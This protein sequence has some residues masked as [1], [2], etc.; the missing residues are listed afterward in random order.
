VVLSTAV[1]E[2]ERGT[3]IVAVTGSFEDYF[4]LERTIDLE[5][6]GDSVLSAI[7][8][9]REMASGGYLVGDR[10]IPW[11]RVYDRDGGIVRIL[12]GQ[13]DGP[14]EFRA[15]SGAVETPH[16]I[17]VTD[18][19]RGRVTRFSAIDCAVDTIFRVPGQ[20][21]VI[22][23]TGSE[24]LIHIWGRA[25]GNVLNL[26]NLDL[27]SRVEFKP[28]DS[29]VIKTPYWRS[30]SLVETAI[31]GNT[32]LAVDE[33]LYPIEVYDMDGRRLGEFGTPPP[34]WQ[35][36]PPV[37][38]A[39]FAGP[40]MAERS[41]E[42]LAKFTVMDRIDVYRDSYV[43]VTHARNAPSAT[44]LFGRDHYAIDV[45]D[46]QGRKLLEDIP[47]PGEIVGAGDYLYAVVGSPPDPWKV[48][49]F[50]IKPL[51]VAGG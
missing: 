21:A 5:E 17:Y 47:V 35:P 48:G 37:E 40:D 18:V 44:D 23:F 43:V 33:F 4:S 26:V 8:T 32:I 20:P 42:W 24:L 15:V 46:K 22:D 11:L 50:A 25:S 27:A 51:E 13:G 10:H 3:P 30:F 16:G 7:G 14:G 36:A 34:S 49:M 39:A 38:Y 1:C 12:G 2:G 6:R 41:A 45:Y 9:F 28:V 31:L 29:L 19:D